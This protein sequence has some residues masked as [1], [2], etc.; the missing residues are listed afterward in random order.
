MR[1]SSPCAVRTL[2]IMNDTP[3]ILDEEAFGQSIAAFRA[4]IQP[5][6]DEPDEP[7]TWTMDEEPGT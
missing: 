5:Q 7:E 4:A 1:L 2:F 3:E 6:A